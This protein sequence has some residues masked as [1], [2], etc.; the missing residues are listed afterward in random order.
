[1]TVFQTRV[2]T[3]PPY[4]WPGDK[5]TAN[6]YIVAGG[7]KFS[8][9]AGEN[10]NVGGF[11]WVDPDH[12]T[13]L[14]SSGTE[15]PIGFVQRY[16]YGTDYSGG[17]NEKPIVYKGTAV[18]PIA[19]GDFFIDSSELTEDV[20]NNSPVYCD[21]KTGKICASTTDGAIETGYYYKVVDEKVFYITAWTNK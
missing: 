5:A 4:G 16:R 7:G 3:N 9:I 8:Y 1:M 21:P 20:E 10:L 18:Q 11:C 19:K 6:P 15:T 2:N 17:M 12:S 14:V 13:L